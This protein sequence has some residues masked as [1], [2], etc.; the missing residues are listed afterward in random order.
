MRGVIERARRKIQI[1]PRQ[2]AQ[3]LCG[4]AGRQ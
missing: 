4:L 3:E 1:A 2:A